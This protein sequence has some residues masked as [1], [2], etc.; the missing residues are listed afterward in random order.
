MCVIG[1]DDNLAGGAFQIMNSWGTEWG[2]NG[3]G[4]VR[5][6]DFAY[7]NKEAFGLYPMVTKDAAL[8]RKFSCAIGMVTDKKE[9]I[10]LAAKGNGT[11]ESTV[12]VPKG[13]KFKMYVKNEVECF[14]YIFG[15]ET[16]GSSYTL[17]PYT[18]KHS[19]FCGITGVRLFPKGHSL[20]VDNAGNKDFMAVVVTKK[21]IDYKALNARIN[22]SKGTDYAAKVNAAVADMSLKNVQFGS[23]GKTMQ[24]A[25]VAPNDNKAVV[26][27]VAINK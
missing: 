4:W 19:P 17:F 2:E 11:F 14:T 3:I 9:F 15:Q 7:F 16:N 1:Y 13:T 10:P 27:V 22:I 21:P 24:F 25:A 6:E 23:D 26:C 12:K 8:Q 18:P 5:Y 20:Q